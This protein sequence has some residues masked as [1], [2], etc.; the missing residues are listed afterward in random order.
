MPAMMNETITPG[1]A[2]GTAS[3]STKKMPVP[4]V[5]PIPNIA[6][7][8]VPIERLRFGEAPWATGALI[9][10]RLRNICSVSRRG[11]AVICA[12]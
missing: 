1:P 4:T 3:D 8:K 9:S 12:S 6:S 11:G 10:G 2:C 5:E 7:W